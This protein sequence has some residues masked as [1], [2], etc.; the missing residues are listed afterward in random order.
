L[1]ADAFLKAFE[2]Q[3]Q[4]LLVATK[5]KEPDMASSA[6]MD[7]LKSLQKYMTQVDDIRQS[8]RASN[9][10]DHL[11]MVA[12]GVGALAWVTIKPKPQDYVAELFGG[13]QLYGNKVL[14]EYKDKYGHHL[15]EDAVSELTVSQG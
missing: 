9:L 1:Q 7:T 5:A 8:N 13:A 10:K 14:K 12:D 3:R 4:F 6:Y 11:A 15:N 2:A